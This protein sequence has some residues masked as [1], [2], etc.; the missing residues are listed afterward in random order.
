MALV[1]KASSSDSNM[2]IIAIGEIFDR[3]DNTG[4]IAAE[5]TKEILIK[6]QRFGAF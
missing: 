6:F 3:N 5:K 1:R 4:A 2:K